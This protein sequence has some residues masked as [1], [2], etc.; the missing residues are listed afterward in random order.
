ML[1]VVDDGVV[2]QLSGVQTNPLLIPA[3]MLVVVALIV[4]IIAMTMPVKATIG[5][6]AVLAVL[7]FVFNRY[8][9]RYQYE[10]TIATGQITV[11]NRHFISA[12]HAVKLSN[13]ATIIVRHHT[14]TIKDLGRVWHITGFDN[15]KE[16]L[17]AQSVLE[18]KALQ[19]R[20]Q[21]I[22]IM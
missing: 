3:A 21:P 16:C 22:R 14:L 13:D 7:I 12:G 5:A 2:I 8:K 6:M 19:K 1:K 17:I 15:E 18:G 4:A 20:E 10:K 11:K 9:Q